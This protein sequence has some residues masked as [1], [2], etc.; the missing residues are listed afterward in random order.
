MIRQCSIVIVSL[1]L[2]VGVAGSVWAG[3]PA[4][5]VRLQ[6]ERVVKVLADPGLKRG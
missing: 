5:Q 4:D 6:I 3:M 2:A 1:I